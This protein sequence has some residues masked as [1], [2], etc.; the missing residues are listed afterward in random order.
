MNQSDSIVAI[1]EATEMT[2]GEVKQFFDNLTT[3]AVKV[4]RKQDELHLPGLGKLVSG[5]RKARKGRNPQTGAA[6]KI[7]AK[8][9]V[10]L[11]IAKSLKD[12]IE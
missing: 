8:K 5:T 10:K 1:S 3:L 4:V 12:E 11:K 9:F 7:P 6:L 2:K